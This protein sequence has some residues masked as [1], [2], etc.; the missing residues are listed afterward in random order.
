MDLNNTLNQLKNKYDI[1]DEIKSLKYE[2]IIAIQNMKFKEQAIIE[3][4]YK[5]SVEKLKNEKLKDILNYL[6]N[7]T[8]ENL[9]IDENDKLNNI[10][11]NDLLLECRTENNKLKNELEEQRNIFD[12]LYNDVKGISEENYNIELQIKNILDTTNKDIYEK[13]KH[14]IIKQIH[15]QI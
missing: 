8:L 14:L 3:E 4:N 7:N 6:S 11:L 1:I 12:K 15:T 10:N 2:S 5:L 13:N 9:F